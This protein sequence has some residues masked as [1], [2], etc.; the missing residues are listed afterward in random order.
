VVGED[1][2]RHP[3]HCRKY[4]Q[5]AYNR[6]CRLCQKTTTASY[7]HMVSPL[8]VLAAYFA[9]V[10]RRESAA[11][12]VGFAATTFALATFPEIADTITQLRLALGDQRYESLTRASEKMT[13]AAIAQYALDQIDQARAELKA[14]SK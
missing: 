3:P 2:E 11:T 6:P 7:S 9:R 4:R 10:G 14:V 1:T 8:G 13:N 12:L 5:T